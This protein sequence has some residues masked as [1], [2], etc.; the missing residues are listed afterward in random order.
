MERFDMFFELNLRSK[1]LKKDTQVNIIIPDA[2]EPGMSFKTMWLLHGLNGNHTSWMRNTAI[3]RYAAKYNLAVI[4]PD[5][6][7]SW[8]TNTVYGMNYFNFITEELP[9]LCRNT[10]KFLSD[11]REDNI[12]AGLSMGGYGAVKTALSFPERYGTCIS[13]SGSLDITRKG[14]PCN[15]NEWRSIFNFNMESPLELEGSEHDLF[16]LARKNKAEGKPFSSLYLWCGTEDALINVNR[17]FDELLTSLS[18]PHEFKESEGDH[19]WKWWD[20]HIQN[21]LR[22]VFGE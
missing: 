3:E 20:M 22:W 1:E 18:V 21:A 11:K 7:R 19:S 5:A 4:M 8:Y 9:E 13:L 15:L 16:T 14:R 2:T 17:S 12:V 10:F 6:E